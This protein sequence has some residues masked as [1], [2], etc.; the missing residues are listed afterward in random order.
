[1]LIGLIANGISTSFNIKTPPIR[2]RPPCRLHPSRL[3]LR[4]SLRLLGA[5]HLLLSIPILLRETERN[6]QCQSHGGT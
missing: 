4:P 6:A 1:L 2:S 3:V 5:S